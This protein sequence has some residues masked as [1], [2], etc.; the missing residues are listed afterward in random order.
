MPEGKGRL[1]FF[2]KRN[3]KLLRLVP[4]TGD[5][6]CTMRPGREQEFFGSFLQKRTLP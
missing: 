3:K 5:A 1:S 6:R 4:R 2:E